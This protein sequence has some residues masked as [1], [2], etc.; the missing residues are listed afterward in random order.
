MFE[1]VL[2]VLKQPGGL[3]LWLAR[4]ADVRLRFNLEEG[5]QWLSSVGGKYSGAKESQAHL[6]MMD[7]LL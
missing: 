5:R 1:T 6:P 2:S 3:G 4:G 7:W